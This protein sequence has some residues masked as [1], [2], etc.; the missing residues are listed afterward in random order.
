MSNLHR[1]SL[2]LAISFAEYIPHRGTQH[3]F[4]AVTELTEL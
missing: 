2:C 4:D 3:E 1:P